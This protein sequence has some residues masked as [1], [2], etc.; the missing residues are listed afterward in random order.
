M[1]VLVVLL[2]ANEAERFKALGLQFK[3]ALLALCW[4]AFFAYVIP[5]LIGQTG[6]VVFLASMAVGCV[7]LVAVSFFFCRT[8]KGRSW[9]PWAAW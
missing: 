8:G 3:F 1:A 7:P 9:C 4:L 5:V 6:L 2:F